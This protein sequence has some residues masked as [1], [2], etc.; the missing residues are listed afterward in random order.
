MKTWIKTGLI[1]GAC[2]YVGMVIVFP[3]LSRD[4]S[5]FKA[6]AGIPFWAVAGLIFG[7]I[8]GRK[9]TPQKH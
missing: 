7:Y 3:C 5:W 1:W 2:M 6:L 9:N 8:T 4:F